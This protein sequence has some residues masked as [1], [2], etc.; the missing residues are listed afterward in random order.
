MYVIHISMLK[1]GQPIA[2][3]WVYEPEN[4]F[5]KLLVIYMDLIHHEF[6]N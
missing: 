5:Y 2:L 3:A 1:L 4:D 6:R